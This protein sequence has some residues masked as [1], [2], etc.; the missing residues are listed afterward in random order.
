VSAD[1][2]L[3]LANMLEWED[4]FISILGLRRSLLAQRRSAVSA[5]RQDAI[6]LALWLYTGGSGGESAYRRSSPL[7]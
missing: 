4:E 3:P 7:F 6:G 5:S 1:Q 2:F